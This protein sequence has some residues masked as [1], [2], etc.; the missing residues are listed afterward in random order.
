MEYEILSVLF[1]IKVITILNQFI[2]NFLNTIWGVIYINF[3][4]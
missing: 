2:L 4:N 1:F 3:T